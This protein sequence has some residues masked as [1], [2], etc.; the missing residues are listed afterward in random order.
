MHGVS[1]WVPHAP[2]EHS[3]LDQ[4]RARPPGHACSPA[5]RGESLT[6]RHQPCDEGSESGSMTC[7]NVVTGSLPGPLPSA[8]RTWGAHP[9][10]A[11]VTGGQ[12]RSPFGSEH[13]RKG[14]G[15]KLLPG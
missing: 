8:P 14:R 11:V 5:G 10:K 12:A 9:S 7:G 1:V 6:R 13:L 2:C 4:A 3:W 15:V